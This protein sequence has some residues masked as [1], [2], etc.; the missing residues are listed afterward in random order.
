MLKRLLLLFV[1]L[2]LAACTVTVNAQTLPASAHVNWPPN[3]AGDQVTAY[4]LTLD[5]NTPIV[6]PPTLDASCSC[7]RQQITIT[8]AGSHTITLTAT[9]IWGT[10]LP[11][12]LTFNVVVA[13]RPQ[14]PSITVP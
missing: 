10:S 7:I 9:N 1:V 5:A 11:A 4:N 13:S 14:Q 8:T 12:T 3:P 6:V 2:P